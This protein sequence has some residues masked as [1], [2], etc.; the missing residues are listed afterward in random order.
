MFWE[1]LLISINIRIF[2][3]EIEVTLNNTIMALEIKAIPTLHGD[4][5]ERFLKLIDVSSEERSGEVSSVTRR[6]LR[7]FCKRL[8]LDNY[9]LA[10]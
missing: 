8:A 1:N 6:W 9:E 2:V 7:K 10:F 4:A 3:S 5:A